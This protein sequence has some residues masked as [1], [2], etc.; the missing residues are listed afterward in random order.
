MSGGQVRTALVTG[1]SQG[2][3]KATARALAAD[4]YRVIV[5]YGSQQGAAEAVAQGIR[6]NGGQA[7]VV[8]ADLAQPDAAHGLAATV[9][10]LCPDGLHALVLNAAVMPSSDF[11]DCTPETF[12]RIFHTNLRS[13]FFLLQQLTP[14]LVDGASVVWVSS[15]TARRAIGNVAAYGSMKASIESFIRRAA[16]EL[17]PRWIR[18]NGVAPATTA[19]ETVAPFVETGPG[20]DA[21]LAVQALQRIAQ[22]DDVADVIAFLCSDKA[23]WIDG[24]L[25]PVDGGSML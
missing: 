25:I 17:G 23:R 3:G 5:H 7:E 9:A 24:A 22:P 16:V 20:R 4:G 13:P 11:A 19:S 8:Q 2:I 6:E 12:D 21:T 14:T 1:A 10:K 18:V 15:L